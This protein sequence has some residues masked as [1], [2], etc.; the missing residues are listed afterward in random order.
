MM[1]SHFHVLYYFFFKTVLNVSLSTTLGSSH[2]SEVIL[3]EAGSV[4]DDTFLPK[5]TFFGSLHYAVNFTMEILEIF[6]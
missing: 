1:P 3:S 2:H 4:A 5:D 6:F